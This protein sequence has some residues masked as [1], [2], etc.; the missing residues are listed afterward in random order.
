MLKEYK[1]NFKNSNKYQKIKGKIE[2]IE[3]MYKII[4]WEQFLE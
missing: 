4:K 2:E 1:R 3:E